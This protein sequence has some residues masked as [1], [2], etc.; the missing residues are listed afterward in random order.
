MNQEYVIICLRYCGLLE[1]AKEANLEEILAK[2]S[3]TRESYNE[4]LP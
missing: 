1:K 3:M 4:M 2:L